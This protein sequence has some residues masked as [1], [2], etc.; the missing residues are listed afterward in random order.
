[1]TI[2][3]DIMDTMLDTIPHEYLQPRISY[4]SNTHNGC[5]LVIPNRDAR[6]PVRNGSTA[7]PACPIPAMYP[8]QPV[9]IQRGN[10]LVL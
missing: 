9:R 8:M 7:D 4:K 1:M 5:K 10:I 2:I 6:R 3:V